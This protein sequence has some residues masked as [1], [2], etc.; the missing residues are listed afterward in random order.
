MTPLSHS[1]SNTALRVAALCWRSV[2]A[3]RACLVELAHP[4]TEGWETAS[5]DSETPPA[6]RIPIGARCRCDSKTPR[7]FL[8]PR[9]RVE[10]GMDLKRPGPAALFGPAGWS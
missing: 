1:F 7:Q 10:A 3:A 6:P 9:P 5:T 8:A 4:R 2:S